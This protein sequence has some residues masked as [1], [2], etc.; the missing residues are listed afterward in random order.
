MNYF[1][2]SYITS[3]KVKATAPPD[4]IHTVNSGKNALRLALRNLQLPSQSKVAIP[5]YTCIAVNE[6]VREENL[7]PVLFD[8]HSATSYWTNYDSEK[9]LKENIKAIVL[10]H[11]YG[12]IH[13]DT[14][15]LT[16]FCLANNI[17]LVHDAAQSYG[18]NENIL[19]KGNGI[20][21]SFGP[22]KSLTAAGGGWIKGITNEFY[23]KNVKFNSS[24]LL[25]NIYSELF[26]KTR[27]YG[28]TFIFSDKIK[29]FINAR[30]K[31]STKEITSMSNFAKQVNSYS[32]LI[33]NDM[34]SARKRNYSTLKEAVSTNKKIKIPYDDN[35]GQ[36]FKLIPFVENDVEDFKNYLLKNNIPH[37]ALFKPE[38]TKN[39]SLA[40]FQ[41][42]GHNFIDI[43]CEASIPPEE[44]NRIADLL[45]NY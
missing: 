12:F 44:I 4:F 30:L 14:E 33:Q 45:K 11:L 19:M 1:F 6:A 42:N 31:Y 34:A 43:S 21:Y 24:S 13:P 26:L 35:K 32:L 41:K 37:F 36:Y 7:E 10:V 22:G 29:S 17:K 15:V 9:L 25:S 39:S 16:N 28:Y 8:M 3:P 20:I 18:I 38:Y 23:S 40:N 27:I 2:P 5:A